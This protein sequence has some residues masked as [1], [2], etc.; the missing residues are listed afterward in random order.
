MNGGIYVALSGAVAQQTSLESTA[1]NLANASTQGYQKLRPV[2]HEALGKAR[3]DRTLRYSSVDR[4]TIDATPQPVRVT[5]RTH[6]VAL[7]DGHYLAVTTDRGERYTRAGSLVV[8]RTGALT[9][10]S[11]HRVLGE[12][13]KPIDLGDSTGTVTLA[14]DGSVLVGGEV[15]GRI[16]VVRFDAPAELSHD[17]ESLLAATT[18]SGSASVVQSTLTVGSLNDSNAS[19]VSGMNELIS[20]SR[21]FEAFQRAIDAFREIDRAAVTK[22]AGVE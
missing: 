11:G 19:P 8:G 16:R 21:S 14:Q 17:G 5:G 7:E 20:A 2:F 15:Q 6:D 10:S 22:V 18:T 4:T 12:N 13:G 1:T 3:A 9:T